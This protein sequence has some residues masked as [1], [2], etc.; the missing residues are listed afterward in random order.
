MYYIFTSLLS[1]RKYSCND[2]SWSF[3]TKHRNYCQ[4]LSPSWWMSVSSRYTPWL[5]IPRYSIQPA[6]DPLLH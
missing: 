1:W 5:L 2:I 4:N 6:T 3:R